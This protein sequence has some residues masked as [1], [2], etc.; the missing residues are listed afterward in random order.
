MR[1][2][3]SIDPLPA[4][5]LKECFSVLLPVILTNIV[6]LSLSSRTVPDNLKIAAL[7]PKLKKPGA[8]FTN[9]ESFRPLSNLKFVS[10][11]V[12]K[13]ASSL[14]SYQTTLLLIICLSF[15][16]QHTSHITLQRLLYL[17]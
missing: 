3:C 16:N 4:C 12:E 17:K 5:V 10:K 15:S 6:N 7:I 9:F 1:K 8:D 13:A 14:S 11:L 2:S